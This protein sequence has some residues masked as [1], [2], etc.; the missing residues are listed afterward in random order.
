MSELGKFHG[1]GLQIL[2]FETDRDYG[3]NGWAL[4]MRS[5]MIIEREG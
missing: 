1:S 5:Y 4:E 3:L 2:V